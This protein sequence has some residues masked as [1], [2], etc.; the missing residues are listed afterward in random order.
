MGFLLNYEMP[1]NPLSNPSLVAEQAAIPSQRLNL[2][3]CGEDWD[4]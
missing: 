4:F 3:D 2:S 1:S